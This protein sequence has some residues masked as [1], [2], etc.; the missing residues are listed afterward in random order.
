MANDH[1]VPCPAET[2]T[3]AGVAAIAADGA[4][5]ETDWANTSSGPSRRRSSPSTGDRLRNRK[6]ASSRIR[7]PSPT[8]GPERRWGMLAT[9][10]TAM[11]SIDPS[12][13]NRGC[14]P[15]FE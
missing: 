1:T 2:A 11:T 15:G 13:E 4:A 7:R 3:I 12:N 6:R 14:V 5:P 9:A 8:H 10:C